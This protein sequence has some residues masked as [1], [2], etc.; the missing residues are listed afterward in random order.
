MAVY[1]R[2]NVWH[3]E[4]ELNGTRY[5]GSTGK[6]S[7]A[8]AKEVETDKRR[9]AK[10][11]VDN[12]GT[13]F[14][15]LGEVA[16]AWL[17]EGVTERRDQKNNESRVRK[18]FG[19]E[20]KYD[21]K[22]RTWV[23]GPSGRF[24]FERGMPFHQLTNTMLADLVAA[25]RDE[26]NS[27]GTINRELALIQAFVA[28]ARKRGVKLPKDELLFGEQKAAERKPKTRYLSLDEEAQ[29]LAAIVAK[30]AVYKDQTGPQARMIQDQFDLVVFLLDTGARYNEVAS[31]T[32][33]VVDL[34]RR[35]V[36]LYRRKV[37]NEG[38]LGMTERL[39][40]LLTARWEAQRSTGSPYIFPAWD[41]GEVVADKPRGWATEGIVET[42]DKLGFNEPRKVALKGRATAHSFRDTFAA[43]QL[44]AGATLYEVQLLLGHADPKQTQKYAHLDPTAGRR[45]ASRL[46]TLH[47]EASTKYARVTTL[48]AL[49][50]PAD[51][52][53]KYARVTTLSPTQEDAA[54]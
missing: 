17:T 44:V 13:K 1:K 27:G 4:F 21:A 2:G 33:E 38:G 3:Y 20:L 41:R 39:H 9:E 18:L 49:D 11:A 24:M 42:M 32:W 26:G 51:A 15:T 23:E 45:S 47:G 25:R 5:R 52:S 19:R 28:L 22:T 30:Q 6:T 37:D 31:L 14:W 7:K 8:E 50:A 29:L 48:S 54:A 53:T 16:D 10:E 46:D 34:D 12:P 43:R 40:R 35:S 36:H